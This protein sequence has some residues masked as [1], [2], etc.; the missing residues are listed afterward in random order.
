MTSK[1]LPLGKRLDRYLALG[2]GLA[3]FGAPFAVFSFLILLSVPLTAIGIACVVLGASVAL[4]PESPVP[5]ETI[6]AMVEGSC[7]SLE[8]LLEEFN[9]KNKVIYLPPRDGRVT[10]YVSTSDDQTKAWSAI[11]AP[12]RVFSEVE[13]EA[14]LTLFPPGSEI[15]RLSEI[16]EESG[17]DDALSYVLVDFLEAVESVKSVEAGR[18]TIVSMSKPRIRSDFPRFNTCLGTLPTSI[19]GC[20]LAQVLRKPVGLVEEQ[21]TNQQVIATFEVPRHPG[22]T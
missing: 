7:A 11:N 14:A 4:V 18:R 6:R 5:K 12:T 10:A 22:E 20:I 9:A 21:A 8:S 2:L 15:V 3:I 17:V 1:G 16:G 19:A 13:G